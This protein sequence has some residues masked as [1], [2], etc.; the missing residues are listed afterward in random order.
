MPKIIIQYQSLSI[1]FPT[2]IFFQVILKLVHP[3]Y[4]NK[5]IS[6]KLLVK[7]AIQLWFLKKAP[8]AKY[9]TQYN[10]INKVQKMIHTKIRFL[11]ENINLNNKNCYHQNRHLNIPLLLMNK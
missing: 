11:K 4:H 9:Q 3:D 8:K 6:I 7:K 5:N 1:V 2:S 10:R